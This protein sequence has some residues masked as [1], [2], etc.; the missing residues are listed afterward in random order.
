MIGP[1]F[2][3]IHRNDSKT[4]VESCKQIFYYLA[5]RPQRRKREDIQYLW[6]HV[7]SMG[8]VQLENSRL[9]TIEDQSM[10]EK[11]SDILVTMT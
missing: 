4:R 10:R 3:Q 7:T 8:I 9:G 6:K 11:A 1:C 2:S 5:Q